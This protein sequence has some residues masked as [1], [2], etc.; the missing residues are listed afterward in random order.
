MDMDREAFRARF[1]AYKEGKPV[2]EIYDAGLPK[3][4]NGKLTK[5]QMAMLDR[6]YEW[7]NPLG[8]DLFSIAGMGGNGLQES[9][10][11]PNIVSKWG[12]SGLFQNNKSLTNA[13][14]DM[15]GDNS[16]ESQ[17]KYADEWNNAS[18]RIRK[19]KHAAWTAMNAG[20]FKKKGYASATDA[21]NAWM[22]FYERPVIL[23][24]NGKLIGYQQQDKR[25]AYA[26]AAYDYLFSKYGNPEVLKAASQPIVAQQDNTRVVTPTP[27]YIQEQTNVTTQNNIIPNR[28]QLQQPVRTKSK[29][30]EELFSMI[31]ENDE[32][33]DGI[34]YAKN[35]KLPKYKIGHNVSN[36]ELNDDGTF[37]DDY[38]K[39]F[40]DVYVTPKKLEIRRNSHTWNNW[41]YYNKHRSD[42][43]KTFMS[44][45]TNEKGL[46]LTY[47]EFDLL[48]GGRQ[49]AAELLPLKRQQKSNLDKVEDIINWN[50][51]S[52]GGEI[53]KEHLKE[54]ADIINKY[55]H[56]PQWLLM[57]DGSKFR[58]DP[59]SW[60]QLMSNS[61]KQAGLREGEFPSYTNIGY[62]G[63]DRTIDP[64]YTGIQWFSRN[65]LTGRSFAV[66]DA[67]TLE[68]AYPW[69]K[70][71]STFD[72]GGNY[73]PA[74]FKTDSG[75]LLETN[76]IVDFSRNAQSPLEIRNVYELGPNFVLKS[77]YKTPEFNY[78]K[79]FVSDDVILYDG[80]PRKSILYNNGDFDLGNRNMYYKNGKLPSYSN[81]K[82]YIKPANRGKLT[83]LKARTGKSESELYN[84]GNPAHKKMVVFARNAR[85]W[86]H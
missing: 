41:D 71:V 9:G 8:Y 34:L 39:I 73:W 3:Y 21:A 40:D 80:Y 78:S 7:G 27:Q 51:W 12:Y 36:A 54:Y 30:G 55:Q 2:S 26:N 83:R 43:T 24:A 48:L 69:P 85:K 66:N 31:F 75:K 50:N 25:I 81:G 44:S 37:T 15:Y 22:K 68:M 42:W 72:A 60:I 32:P 38:T 20:K 52:K 16:L 57:E 47:P 79:D 4:W 11:N 19:G 61:A 23:D 1:K 29:L 45:G 70:H 59:R 49:I 17:L 63:V 6:L 76:H 10:L 5:Q 62:S 46:E 58:G 77:K 35:G 33:E 84:D 64:S 65:P 67:H 14:I 86:K 28:L 13:I 53:S 56:T 82:I 18:E 74:I